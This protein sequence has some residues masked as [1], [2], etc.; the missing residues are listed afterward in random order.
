MNKKTKVRLSDSVGT[1]AG[2]LNYV[3]KDRDYQVGITAIHYTETNV[4]RVEITH[5]PDCV[6]FKDSQGV[7]WLNVDGVHDNTVVNKIGEI[8]DL[9]PLLLEDVVSTVQRPKLDEYDEQMFV[10][11]KMLSYSGV[12]KRVV[13]EQVSLVLGKNYVISFQEDIKGDFSI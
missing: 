3:G 6:K 8:F 4:E 5:I 10:V 13:N 7:L 2:T 12:S 1:E 9:H 11:L